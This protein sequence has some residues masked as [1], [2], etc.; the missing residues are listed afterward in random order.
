EESAARAVATAGSAVVFAGLTVM[1]ALAGLAVA[2]IPFLTTMGMAAAVG[3][4][5]AVCIALTLLPATLRLAGERLRPK[6][7]KRP[8]TRNR[9]RFFGGW[10]KAATKW[11][12]VTILVI[13]AGLG[14]LALPARGLQLALPDNGSAAAGSPARVNYD[15][16]GKYYG[17]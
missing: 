14:A 15:L 3:V 7:R 11:P 2:G 9:H 8:T 1:I 6:P 13:I 17:A 12:V 16:V 5:I 4:A 10:V